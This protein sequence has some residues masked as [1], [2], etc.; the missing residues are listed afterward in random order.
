MFEKYFP[1]FIS[2]LLSIV[3]AEKNINDYVAKHYHVGLYL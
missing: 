3:C 1:D 2:E